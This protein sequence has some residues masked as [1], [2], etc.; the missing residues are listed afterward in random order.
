MIN[1]EYEG[2]KLEQI[3]RKF[4]NDFECSDKI[5]NTSVH[6]DWYMFCG[7]TKLII[8]FQT[9][10]GFTIA[11]PIENYDF[12][13]ESLKPIILST[14]IEYNIYSFSRKNILRKTPMNRRYR[15]R[16]LNGEWL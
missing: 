2:Y 14:L 5:I 9:N 6:V 10:D 16:L 13:E 3:I 11:I 15:Y 7:S 8:Y 4:I 1:N 12:T